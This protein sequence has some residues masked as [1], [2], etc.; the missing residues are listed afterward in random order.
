MTIKSFGTLIISFSLFCIFILFVF[1][2]WSVQLGIIDN[3]RY[4][5]LIELSPLG[6]SSGELAPAQ[7]LTL[8]QGMIAP[9]L[10]IIVGFVLNRELLD[11]E[12]LIKWMPFLKQ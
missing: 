9:I 5:K 3:I 8:G 4:A 7:N 12:L 2:E 10:F 6:Y 1:S 11:N